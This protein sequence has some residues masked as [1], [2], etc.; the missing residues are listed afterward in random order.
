MA[1]VAKFIA[2]TSALSR[3]HLTDV[4]AM[5]A[6]LIEAGI[7]ATC[8]AI[9]FEILWSTRS[10]AEFEAVHDDRSIGYEWLATEDADWHRALEVQAEFWAS[11]RMRT[12]PLPDLLI[13]T[14]AERHRVTILHYDR[15]Y[16]LINEITGQPTQWVVPQ[17]S[18]P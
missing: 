11:A 14:V 15:D 9:E 5:L 1:T 12:V 17:G 2:D 8:A 6:P 18:I 3:L 7:V 10:P 16:D 4:N 13:A